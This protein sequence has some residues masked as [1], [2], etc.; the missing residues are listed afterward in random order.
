MGHFSH[1]TN[2]IT[3]LAFK[4]GT[5]VESLYQIIELGEDGVVAGG[6]PFQPDARFVRR[7][8]NLD[9]G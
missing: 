9:I 3:P 2:K 8:L 7:S 4:S 6:E 5:P 1:E